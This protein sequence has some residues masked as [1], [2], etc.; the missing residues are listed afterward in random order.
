M[1]DNHALSATAPATPQRD[2]L[3]F[4]RAGRQSLHPRLLADDPGR[5]WDCCIN[6]WSDA[7]ADEAP[8]AEAEMHLPGGLNKFE[9]Y[10]LLHDMLM[11]RRP[12][13]Y[14]LMLDDDLSF[15]PGAVSRFFEHCEREQLALAQ[16]AI[17][18]GSHSNHVINLR[19]PAC[20]VRRVNFV[21]VMA[22]CF[23]QAML[24][25]LLPTFGLTRC[26][27]GMDYAWSSLLAGTDE[28]IAIVDDVEMQ[29]TKP[30]DVTGGPFYQR[31]LGMGIDPKQELAWVHRTFTPWGPMRTLAQGHRYRWPLPGAVNA[32]LV[33]A[34]EARK[35]AMHLQRGGTLA[36]QTPAPEVA[37]AAP[38]TLAGAGSLAG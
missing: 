38:T 35:L 10:S 28:N 5:N 2:Y 23:S 20:L 17:A 4:V 12:Y 18:L 9:G 30:M 1:N 31:L 37:T 19:N 6:V 14:V 3:V 25:R 7:T 26:T 21:E 36:P 32:A 11:A 22:P 8:G 15:S 24:E 33:K 29:H 34:L 16:P 13:R 27:W